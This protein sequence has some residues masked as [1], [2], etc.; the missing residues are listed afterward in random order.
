MVCHF[1]KDS[2][3]HAVQWIGYI[4]LNGLTLKKNVSWAN[5]SG[6]D[7]E[8]KLQ[9]FEQLKLSIPKQFCRQ[10]S[11]LLCYLSGHIMN[12]VYCSLTAIFAFIIFNDSID[13]FYSTQLFFSKFPHNNVSTFHRHMHISNDTGSKDVISPGRH[14]VACSKPAS[15]SSLLLE[16]NADLGVQGI[17]FTTLEVRACQMPL[18]PGEGGRGGGR[19]VVVYRGL[20]WLV[21]DSCKFRAFTLTTFDMAVLVFDYMCCQFL[22]M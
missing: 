14:T 2:H 10:P 15:F 1:E 8:T 4:C 12:F 13:M 17:N 18:C 19:G 21:H 16:E 5:G 11:H 3:L 22:S 7:F 6:S 9:P 20:H